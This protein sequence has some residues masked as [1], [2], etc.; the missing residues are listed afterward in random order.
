MPLHDFKCPEHGVFEDFTSW[1]DA[2]GGVTPASCPQCS[3][4]SPRVFTPRRHTAAPH[5]SER[6]AYYEHP[7]T[8]KISVPPRNDSKEL[9]RWHSKQGFERKEALSIRDVARLEQRLG[10]SNAMMRD[11]GRGKA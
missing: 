2:L 4:P 3:N 7:V 10:K 6:V 1:D 9:D 8:G 5:V 11:E